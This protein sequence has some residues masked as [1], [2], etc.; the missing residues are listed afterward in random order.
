MSV[1]EQPDQS[2]PEVWKPSDAQRRLAVE[3]YL[4]Y[5]G[6]LTVFRKPFSETAVELHGL[7]EEYIDANVDESREVMALTAE[8]LMIDGLTRVIRHAN[9]RERGGLQNSEAYFDEASEHMLD[10]IARAY[11][12]EEARIDDLGDTSYKKFHPFPLA[13]EYIYRYVCHGRLYKIETARLLAGFASHRFFGDPVNL[14]GRT[15]RILADA[16]NGKLP[17]VLQSVEYSINLGGRRRL[18]VVK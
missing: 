9:P 5:L 7:E 8:A 4:G 11:S 10:T 1:A 2:T 3:G 13:D 17:E 14:R 16:R 6:G 18:K 15:L 12:L